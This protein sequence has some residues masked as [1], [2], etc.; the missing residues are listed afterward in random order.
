MI[1]DF[2]LRKDLNPLDY[3][4]EVSHIF[5]NKWEYRYRNQSAFLCVDQTSRKI[6]VFGQSS[7]CLAVLFRLAA[8][9]GIEIDEQEKDDE[10]RK[11][12]MYLTDEEFDTITKMRKEKNQ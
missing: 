7:V 5:K 4:F 3:G 12:R 1:I 10:V 9:G 2:Y 11:H 8:M 6:Q